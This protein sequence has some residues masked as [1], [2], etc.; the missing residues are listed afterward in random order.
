[1]CECNDTMYAWQRLIKSSKLENH[2]CMKHILY[3]SLEKCRDVLSE[4]LRGDSPLFKSASLLDNKIGAESKQVRSWNFGNYTSD[5][6]F[7]NI[8]DII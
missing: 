7:R 5:I 4:G 2:F 3:G 6:N 8:E 1:M